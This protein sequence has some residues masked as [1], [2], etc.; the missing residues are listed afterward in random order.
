MKRRRN[1][2]VLRM[3]SHQGLGGHRLQGGKSQGGLKPPRVGV[4]SMGNLW[5]LW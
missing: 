2:K 5:E 3:A 4:E 1:P